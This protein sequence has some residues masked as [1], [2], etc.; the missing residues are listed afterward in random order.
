MEGGKGCGSG[1]SIFL[2]LQREKTAGLRRGIGQ[3]VSVSVGVCMGCVWVGGTVGVGDAAAGER[4]G[5]FVLYVCRIGL[6]YLAGIL[7]LVGSVLDWIDLAIFCLILF[8][9]RGRRGR[10]DRDC[11]FGI[12]ENG[13]YQ[14]DGNPPL[15]FGRTCGLV[16]ICLDSAW[17][18][19][20]RGKHNASCLLFAEPD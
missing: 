7:Y 4:G 6:S 14:R 20:A 15:T 2:S 3:G 17:M 18:V 9:L 19:N 16:R 12:D 5:F 8:G 10:R 11:V 13:G 1:P